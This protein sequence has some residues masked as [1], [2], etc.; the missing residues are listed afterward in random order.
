MCSLHMKGL[1][2]LVVIPSVYLLDLVGLHFL[3]SCTSHWSQDLTSY[4]VAWWLMTR[5]YTDFRNSVHAGH[6]NVRCLLAP[7]SGSFELTD[8]MLRWTRDAVAS[9]KCKVEEKAG[10]PRHRQHLVYDGRELPENMSL[11]HSHV[12]NRNM[13]YLYFCLKEAVRVLIMSPYSKTIYLE[14]WVGDMMLS[15]KREISLW[16]RVRVPSDLQRLTFTSSKEVTDDG[17]VLQ[18]YDTPREASL[19]LACPL[20]TIHV[21]MLT[22]ETFTVEVL[23]SEPIEEVKKKVQNKT[24]LPPEEQRLIHAG[25]L[26][27]DGGALNDYSI[28]KEATVYLIH[29]LR[30]YE[31]FIKNARSGRT[32]TLR[33]EASCTIEY[34]KSM[35]EVKEGVLQHRQQ[36][37]FCGR[38][39]EDRRTLRHYSIANRSTLVLITHSSLGQI[40][41]KTLTGRTLTFDVEV[42]DTVDK[43]K[44]MI[45]R[46]EGIPPH[47]QRIFFAGK[48]LQDGRTLTD[49]CIWKENTL[50]L[51]LCL[52]GGMQI[53]VKRV[54]GETIVLEVE[55]SDMIISV[56]SKIEDK[57]GISQNQQ[58]LFF[59]GNL[60]REL[61]NNGWNLSLYHYNIQKESTLYLVVSLRSSMKV[62]VK[63]HTGRYYTLEVEASELIVTV[64]L[65]IQQEVG[66][67]P[68]QQQLTFEGKELED[69][70]TLSYYNIPEESTL[71]LV[72]KL[73]SGMEIF[74][75]TQM[76]RLYTLMVEA[77]DTIEN[78][79]AK[80]KDK[81]GIPPD[82]QRLI[83][84]IKQLE[85]DRTLSDYDIHENCTLHLVLER[86]AAMQEV[87]KLHPVEQK[88]RD[89]QMWEQALLTEQQIRKEE[90]RKMEASV[91]EMKDALRSERE[92]CRKLKEERE[93]ARQEAE[94]LRFALRAE[95]M[96]SERVR[97]ALV[98]E[99]E[100]WRRD[101]A[102]LQKRLEEAQA[103]LEQYSNPAISDITRWKVSRSDVRIVK[104][105]GT[106][107]WGTV[108]RGV[109][110][111]QPVAVKWPHQ[112][113]LSQHTLERLE[114]ET[115]LMTQ[116]RHPNLVRIIAAV[117]DN[118]SRVL[119]A[120]P[121]I[122]TELLDTD[123]RQCYEQG[124]LQGSSRMPIFRDV[125]YGLHYLHDRQEPIIHR[126]V[127]APNVLLQALPAGMWRA[128]VSDFGSANLARLS[129]TAGEGAVIYTAPE[130]FPQTNPNA[131][132]VPHTTKIDVFSYGI[133]LCEVITAQLPDPELY[134][135][136]LEQVRGQS[137]SLHG[138]ILSCTKPNPDHRPTVAWVIDELY[139]IPQP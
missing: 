132:R 114:R 138:L 9:A 123:L 137:A 73:R 126:D 122:V 113:I 136:R 65:K 45:E 99:Q 85:E 79:K 82:Q 117:F 127:S 93:T 74:V 33:V 89:V 39:L 76:G 125:A 81:A 23:T 121:M 131:P 62:C 17:K 37:N 109:Y 75:K 59:C 106:G 1:Y 27:D 19:C 66:V 31:I 100:K 26:V 18:C 128:K 5:E 116:V 36:L 78:V 47:Q 129:K 124:R 112:Y 16:Q 20:T 72:P 96:N 40:F 2:V 86:E 8:K 13:L 80:I 98:A 14:K 83:F 38:P 24:G 97:R 35:I 87:E 12:R 57:V 103:Q 52:R 55:A 15:A 91:Q 119:Q 101:M 29:R 58:Q 42:N 94:R 90:A 139:T 61:G 46:K 70:R 135:E 92:V 48:L 11:E 88:V 49:Y 43:V 4:S 69:G 115:Q 56:K 102:N 6:V 22:G 53:F 64:K 32:L 118:E 67:P 84:G 30:G 77:S 10:L 54:F 71:C 95:E 25:T 108:T 51:C 63:T 34:L 134:L 7:V 28:Q 50:D 104:E 44:S 130:A 21:K 107:A 110:C 3:W 41:V 133:L 120:P 68:G 111:G 105:I 60:L